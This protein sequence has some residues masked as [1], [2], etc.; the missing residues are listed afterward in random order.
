MRMNKDT[1]KELYFPLHARLYRIAFALIGNSQ[2][3]E[4]VLQDTYCKLWN[5]HDELD[6]VRN[7]EAFCTTLVRNQALD[8]LRCARNR[9]Q[10]PVTEAAMSETA[11]SPESD[12]IRKEKMELLTHL[13]DQLPVNQRQVL[14]LRG[15]QGLTLEEVGALTGLSDVNVRVLLSR[16]RKTL[17]EQFQIRMSD[18]R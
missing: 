13:I 10:E 3:A 16:A 14:R 15:I 4:D 2:D 6:A 7:T 18:E 17:R 5:M 9:S 1:F 8:F 12:L 11:V